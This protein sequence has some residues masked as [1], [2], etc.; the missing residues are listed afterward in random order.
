MSNSQELGDRPWTLAEANAQLSKI[1]NLAE[2]QG[3]QRMGDRKRFVVIPEVSWVELQSPQRTP[4][5][6]WLIDNSPRGTSLVASDRRSLRA[7]PFDDRD[8]FRA[9]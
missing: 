7:T 5:G 1:L 6:Q 4:L 8:R 9:I 3:P 2:L